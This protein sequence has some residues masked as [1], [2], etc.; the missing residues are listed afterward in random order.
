MYNHLFGE[1]EI[2]S[3]DLSVR[4]LFDGAGVKS[5]MS[6][7]VQFSPGVTYIAGH[8]VG[9]MDDNIYDQRMRMYL[10]DKADGRPLKSV[11]QLGSWHH[12]HLSREEL[13]HGIDALDVTHL[14]DFKLDDL[15]DRE[16]L[17]DT[18]NLVVVSG[19]MAYSELLKLMGRTA[20]NIPTKMDMGMLTVEVAI[21]QDTGTLITFDASID[22]PVGDVTRFKFGFSV[23]NLNNSTVSIPGAVQMIMG[24]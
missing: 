5:D 11:Y 23:N 15:S 3:G 13:E 6:A 1:D 22:N 14:F 24:V 4:F 7:N 12:K 16:L 17:T 9:S 2:V 21:D 8:A 10:T 20:N 18:D 19:K